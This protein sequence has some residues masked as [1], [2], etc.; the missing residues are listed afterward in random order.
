[1]VL[2]WLTF[3][4]GRWATIMLQL[5]FLIATSYPCTAST[6]LVHPYVRTIVSEVGCQSGYEW[7]N[8]QENSDPC[9]VVAYVLAA[10]FGNSWTQ[11]PL[12]PG[13]WYNPPNGSFVTPCYC[14]WSGYNLLM[15]CTYCQSANDTGQL[16]TWQN[17]TP[18][19]PTSYTDESFPSG[20]T[21][22]AGETIPYWATIDP[23]TWTGQIWDE[24]QAYEYSLQG[25]PDLLPSVS[26]GSHSSDLAAIVGGTV[27]GV[28]FLLL[29]F[30]ICFLC[31]R[32]R[33]RRVRATPVA[34][35]KVEPNPSWQMRNRQLS[36]QSK[37][38]VSQQKNVSPATYYTGSGTQAIPSM[39]PS[40]PPGLYTTSYDTSGAQPHPAIPII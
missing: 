30:G 13:N 25:K 5:L 34:E 3:S 2:Q 19:C 27:G 28:V 17:F 16:L 7:M 10:C 32:R 20:Y 26:T 29:S 11:P 31:K 14:S 39:Y 18:N 22:L 35:I 21:L 8:N 23:M 40:S 9:R 37:T 1:M 38:S 36:D 15:A 33:Y 24:Q 6:M 12:A 4:L